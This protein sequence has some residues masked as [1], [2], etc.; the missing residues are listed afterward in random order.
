[1]PTRIAIIGSGVSGLASFWALHTKTRA[2]GGKARKAGYEVHL[3]ESCDYFGGHTQSVRWPGTDSLVDVAFSLFN[4]STYPNFTAFLAELQVQVNPAPI[5][6]GLSRDSDNF[7]WSSKSIGTLFPQW[8]CLFSLE[9]WTMLFEICRFNSCAGEALAPDYE[10]KH[11]T[12]GSYL[13][14]NGYAWSF[15]KNYLFPLLSSIWIHNPGSEVSSMPII[16]VVQY[17]WNH[18]LLHTFSN[19]VRWLTVRG[20]AKQYVDKILA[21]APSDRLHISCPVSNVIPISGGQ[22]KIQFADQTKNPEMF[23]QVVIATSGPE[24]LKLLGAR[25]TSKE[26]NILSNFKTT[27]PSSIVLHSDTS[28][29]PRNPNIWSAWNYHVS[30]RSGGGTQLPRV[31]LTA[32]MKAIMQLEDIKEPV[33]A[34]LNPDFQNAPEG[35][36]GTFQFQHPAYD[37]NTIQAQ[38]LLK[39]IQGIRNVWY[40]GAWTGHGFHED[41]F[42]KG[43]EI[44]TQIRGRVEDYMDPRSIFHLKDWK[45]RDSQ[46]SRFA[47]KLGTI[48]W[49]GLWRVVYSF[50]VIPSYLNKAAPKSSC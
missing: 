19:P 17:L 4:K 11:E 30:S 43:V 10:Y 35:I 20:G 31:S 34:T 21:D 36:V 3:Y 13:Q 44:A 32:D 5:S 14:R 27:N 50:S 29:M 25:A 37:L 22:V 26:Q 28:F 16:M 12:I 45:T 7:E 6:F 47:D 33:L 24:A 41:G 49:K 39:D 2:G 8:S 42:T 40:A 15:Q 18:R 1:M 23:D 38:P 9:R 48:F 46:L